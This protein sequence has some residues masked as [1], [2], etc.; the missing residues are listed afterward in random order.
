MKI[1]AILFGSIWA[2]FMISIALILLIFAYPQREFM[3]QTK[4]LEMS[5]WGYVERFKEKHGIKDSNIANMDGY[6]YV[7]EGRWVTI[8]DI[9]ADIDHEI[10]PGMIQLYTTEKPERSY[11]TWLRQ[12][13]YL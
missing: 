11:E 3:V 5:D 9:K 4:V 6:T 1:T 2:V 13:G 8:Q 10:E 7:F 12:N